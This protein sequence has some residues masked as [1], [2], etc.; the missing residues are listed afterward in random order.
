[1]I[2]QRFPL[3]WC[4]QPVNKSEQKKQPRVITAGGDTTSCFYFGYT[5]FMLISSTSNPKIIRLQKLLRSKKN[6]QAENFFVAEGVR[7]LEEAVKWNT[8]PLELYWGESISDRGKKVVET[9][10]LNAES[11][12]SI[13]DELVAKISDTETSQGIFGIFSI[14]QSIPGEAQFLL[15]ADQIRDPGNLGTLMRS[16][17]AMGVDAVITTPGTVDAYSPKVVRAGMGV[18]FAIPTVSMSWEEIVKKFQ[19]GSMTFCNT[20]VEGGISIVSAPLSFPLALVIGGEAE[21][22]SEN[23]LDRADLNVT[24]PM[25]GNTESLNAGVAGSIALYEVMRR[26]LSG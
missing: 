9:L 11:A 18:H 22:V 5:T 25:G 24:I 20:V 19:S 13:T 8:P 15:I 1:M 7:L 12:F 17:K 23:A 6:R 10:S 16:A 21:G 26:K 14:P 2:P 4:R 3:L